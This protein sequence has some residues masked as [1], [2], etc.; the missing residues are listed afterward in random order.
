MAINKKILTGCAVFFLATILASQTLPLSIV[1]VVQGCV[2]IF[3]WLSIRSDLRKFNNQARDLQTQKIYFEKLFETAP[4][5]IVILGGDDRITKI[6]EGFTR[7]FG[8]TREES[9]GRTIN[10]LIVPADLR[11]GGAFVNQQSCSW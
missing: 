10:E 1:L 6:N 8:Y 9:L 7:M 4:E 5:A 11:G 3:F 2:G